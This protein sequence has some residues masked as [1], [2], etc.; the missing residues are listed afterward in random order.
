[1]KRILIDMPGMGDGRLFDPDA[2]DNCCEPFIHLRD[3]LRTRGYEL[4]TADETRLD[5]AVAIWFWDMPHGHALDQP[6]SGLRRLVRTVRRK[7]HAPQQRTLYDKAVLAG[8]A[9]QMVLFLGEPPVVLSRNWDSDLHQPFRA[10]FTWNDA[11]VDGQRYHKFR[12]P[13]TSR[14]AD[15]PDVPFHDRKLLV[16][17]SGNKTSDDG[18]ELYTARRNTIRYFEY[19]HPALFDLFGTGWNGPDQS[20]EHYPSYRGTVTHKW[21]V[22]P[23][24]RFGICYE[25]MQGEAG[26]VTEKIF[27]CM[28]AGCVPV[29]WGATNIGEFVDTEAFIDRQRFA[30]DAELAAFLLAMTEREHSAYLQAIRRYLASDRFAAF[31]SPAFAAN[32]LSVLSL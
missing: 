19:H 16:N 22:Y 11:Y 3:V 7:Y 12:W 29:Y 5:G 6:A 9:D 2:R 14:F 26:W 4:E 31:L 21:E 8:L 32:V 23:R 24:Y 30:S 17:I 15:V 1:M 10:I 25:N 20:G 27:D 28:R 18:R 13:Q